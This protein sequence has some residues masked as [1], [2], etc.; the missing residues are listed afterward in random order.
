MKK[1]KEEEEAMNIN[2][3]WLMQ[4]NKQSSY[5]WSKLELLKD[6]QRPA[7][8]GISSACQIVKDT[9]KTAS[10]KHWQDKWDKA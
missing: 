5:H 2:G 6:K 3:H 7:N 4:T 1:E 10:N 9:N 8:S